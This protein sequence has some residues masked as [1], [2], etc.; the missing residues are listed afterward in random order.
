MCRSTKAKA[1]VRS[2]ED[3]N[4]QRASGGD[5]WQNESFHL[6]FV[7]RLHLPY[8]DLLFICCA[9]LLY[10]VDSIRSRHHDARSY[11][12]HVRHLQSSILALLS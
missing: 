6:D 12:D 3:H 2:K 5:L 11:Y 7:I 10:I 9:A 4:K 1:K 8:A